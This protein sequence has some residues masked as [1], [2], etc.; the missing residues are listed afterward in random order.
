MYTCVYTCVCRRKSRDEQEKGVSRST[1]NGC[2]ELIVTQNARLKRP[3]FVGLCPSLF[4]IQYQQKELTQSR[5]SVPS[6][7]YVPCMDGERIQ[8]LQNVLSSSRHYTNS[9]AALSMY[10]V[11]D[12]CIELGNKWLRCGFGV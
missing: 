3:D 7:F 11:R 12:V 4:S 9:M 6:G 8:S 10:N 1:A 2:L 5:K